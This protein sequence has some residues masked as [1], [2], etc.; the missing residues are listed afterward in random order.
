MPESEV[1]RAL[2]VLITS[3]FAGRVML[4]GGRASTALMGFQELGEQ[5][6]LAMLPP[7]GTPFRDSDLHE[8][9]FAV[10]ADPGHAEL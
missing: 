7:L 2:Q 8:N 1:T 6:G 3:R 4:F 5:V 9:L 10:S